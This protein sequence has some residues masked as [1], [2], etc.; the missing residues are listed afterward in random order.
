MTPDIIFWRDGTGHSRR[1]QDADAPRRETAVC[2]GQTRH[3]GTNN[4]WRPRHDV[5]RWQSG[6]RK[7]EFLDLAWPQI[8]EPS[9]SIGIKRAKQR[10]RKRGEVIEQIEI[11]PRI[12][13]L[14]ARLKALRERKECLYVFPNRFGNAYTRNGFKAMFGKLMDQAIKEKKLSRRFT[15]HDPR[16]IT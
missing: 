14:L 16:L 3:L 1:S 5:R 8:D 4:R 13:E 12:T 7:I 10:D 15:F 2:I 11:T 9:G 6:N